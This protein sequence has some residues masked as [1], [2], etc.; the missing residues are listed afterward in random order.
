MIQAM[1]TVNTQIITRVQT[2]MQQQQ[3]TRQMQG[4]ELQFAGRIE[5]HIDGVKLYEDLELQV[6]ILYGIIYCYLVRWLVRRKKHERWSPSKICRL[7]PTKPSRNAKQRANPTRS[8][9]KIRSSE[10]E[11]K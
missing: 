3:Q 6:S 11:L 9:T 2:H 8:R 5:A 10:M 4:K 1:Q 7:Q